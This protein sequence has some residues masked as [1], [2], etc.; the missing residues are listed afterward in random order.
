V[1]QSLSQESEESK[2]KKI[3]TLLMAGLF[4]IPTASMVAAQ[5]GAAQGSTAPA[6]SGKHAKRHSKR[7]KKASRKHKNANAANS[8][9]GHSM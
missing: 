3:A 1:I 8:G 6:Q 7:H 5:G 9:S 4:V 2:M